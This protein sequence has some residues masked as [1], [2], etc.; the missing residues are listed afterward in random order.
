MILGL[1][2][3][4][5]QDQGGVQ[6]PEVHLPDFLHQALLH[7]LELLLRNCGMPEQ[8]HG[9]LLCHLLVIYVCANSFG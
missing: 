2:R 6:L 3:Q 1:L 7:S 9:Q 4:R 8:H 5:E